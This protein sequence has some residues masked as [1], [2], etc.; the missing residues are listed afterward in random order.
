MHKSSKYCSCLYYT[1]NAF[2]RA[3][4]RMAD[5]EFAVTGL[6]PSYA[7]LLMTIGHQPGIQPTGISQ[8]MLLKPSTIT[9][10]IEKMEGRG[11]LYRK[12]IGRST[13]VYLTESGERLVPNIQQAWQNLYRRYSD[14]LGEETSKQ[15]TELTFEAVKKMEGIKEEM[16]HGH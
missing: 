16:E 4:T 10:L 12:S 7:F 6:A 13:E 9:R 11:Y 1:A 2:S 14:L 8:T 15:L 3:M 5:E